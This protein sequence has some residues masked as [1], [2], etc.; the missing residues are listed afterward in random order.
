MFVSQGFDAALAG[1]LGLLVGSFLNVVVYRTPVMM[2]R[3]NRRRGSWQSRC[4]HSV[5]DFCIHSGARL[6]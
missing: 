4:S 3:L 1:V 2:Y 6:T 5:P